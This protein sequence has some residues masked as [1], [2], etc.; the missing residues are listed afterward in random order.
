MPPTNTAARGA[1]Y[2]D[3]ATLSAL[4][5]AY[6]RTHTVSNELAAELLK[7]AGGTWDK[8]HPTSSR[9][10]FAQDCVIHLI[11]NPLRNADPKNNLF[12]Y[13]TKCAWRFGSKLGGKAQAEGR[14][15]AA[16]LAAAGVALGEK[17]EAAARFTALSDCKMDAEDL[18]ERA[19]RKARRR[20]KLRA[21]ENRAG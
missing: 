19:L 14:R 21:M 5:R 2:S 1:G 9:E 7:I 4:V 8:Y 15:A 17:A 3:P 16:Y 11:G 10:D 12:G 18:R 6:R 13:F 20:R